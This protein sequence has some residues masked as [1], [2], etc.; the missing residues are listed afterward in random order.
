MKNSKI[1][2]FAAVAAALLIGTIP[3]RVIAAT[4]LT[5]EGHSNTIFG[6]EVT[7]NGFQVGSYGG[8]NFT[9]SGDHFHFLDS[10]LYAVPQNGTSIL[11]EDRNYS[12]TMTESSNRSFD[13]L[14]INYAGDSSITPAATS[15]LVTGFFSAGGST[16]T[17]LPISGTG[18]LS[19]TLT[20]FTNLSSVVFDGTGGGGAFALDNITV[21]VVPEPS[22][23]VLSSICLTSLL[24]LLIDARR[25]GK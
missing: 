16:S 15:L 6:D 3:K 17:T 1:A 22:T 14:S 20:G 13:L 12:I 19:S 24:V 11:D 8:F 18:F 4:V 5:F 21:S 2:C 23:C 10:K 7:S 25:R 9:S